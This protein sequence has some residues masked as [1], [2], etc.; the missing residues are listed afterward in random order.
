ML[1]WNLKIKLEKVEGGREDEYDGILPL[2]VVTED[3]KSSQERWG[4]G[5]YHVFHIVIYSDDNFKK[6]DTDYT[7]IDGLTRLIARIFEI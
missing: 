6:E 7:T 5:A 2:M 3:K 1:I 4:R